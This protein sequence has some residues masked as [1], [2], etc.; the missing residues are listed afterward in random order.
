MELK[1]GF[2]TSEWTLTKAAVVLGCV[3]E[4]AAGTMHALM[5]SGVSAPWFPMALAVCGFVLQAASIFGYQKGRAV[6]KAAAIDAGVATFPPPAS[7]L[8]P[9]PPARPSS[10][11]S[12]GPT[13]PLAP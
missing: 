11:T 10:L 1:P 9:T 5:D 7:S 6:V 2:E 8:M 13:T 4:G 3:L 12:S